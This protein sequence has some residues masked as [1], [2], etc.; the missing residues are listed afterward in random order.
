MI[1]SLA[2]RGVKQV[3]LSHLS[4]EN[5]TPE[6]AYTTIKSILFKNGIIEGQH[7]FIDVAY[8]NKIGTIF[9]L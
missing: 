4:E 7:I 5:N 3:V 6:L 9:D 2:G 8:Q 1:C